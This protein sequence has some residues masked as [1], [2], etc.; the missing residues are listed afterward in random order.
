MDNN[1]T[2]KVKMSGDTSMEEETASGLVPPTV[3]IER[4]LNVI[5]PVNPH[6]WNV[7]SLFEISVQLD[8]SFLQKTWEYLLEYHDVLRSRFFKKNGRWEHIILEAK[9]T[10]PDITRFDFSSIVG[11]EGQKMAIETL[12]R[13]FQFTLNLTAGPIFRIAYIDLG[14]QKNGRILFVAHHLV[15]DGFSIDVLMGDFVRVYTQVSQGRPIKLPHKTVSLKQWAIRLNE[16]VQLPERY[17]EVEYLLHLP[18]NEAKSFPLDYPYQREKDIFSSIEYVKASL[19]NRDTGRLLESTRKVKV[20]VPD[21][22]LTALVR[23]FAKCAESSFVHIGIVRHARLLFPEIDISRTAGYFALTQDVL[24]ES[25][26][27]CTFMGSLQLIKKQFSTMPLDGFGKEIISF[28]TKDENISEKLQSIPRRQ[29]LFN[30]HG[31]HW[32]NFESSSFRPA[33]EAIAPTQSPEEKRLEL[34]FLPCSIDRG[35]FKLSIEY[36]SNFH[37]RETIETLAFL[38]IEELQ[39]FMNSIS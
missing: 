26:L 32:E 5:K 1:A 12:V 33:K 13:E 25:C 39:N 10:K 31:Q 9:E 38:F 16:Y 27:H 24:L 37:K 8:E 14:S 36:S 19:S 34:L 30:Y 6:Y 21:V 22:L 11:T 35:A 2:H 18:W 7:S 4:F 17:Q 20:S 23:S 28:L 29:I 15:V 3:G